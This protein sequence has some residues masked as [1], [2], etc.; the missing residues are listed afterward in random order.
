MKFRHAEVDPNWPYAKRLKEQ[1]GG[2]GRTKFGDGA[3]GK[4]HL[5][6]LDEIKAMPVGKIM[7]AD[8]FI[9]MWVTGPHLHE[10]GD[11]LRTWGF[12]PISCEFVWIKLS[13]KGLRELAKQPMMV[14]ELFNNLENLYEVLLEGIRRLPGNYTAS[15]VEFVVL[16]KRGK[17]KQPRIRMF[18]QLIFSA[19]QEHSRKPDRVKQYIQ[20]AY[21]GSY[22]ELYARRL[23]ENWVTLGN[24]VPGQE[25]L[26]MERSI[27]VIAGLPHG[28]DWQAALLKEKEATEVRK[29]RDEAML[30]PGTQ[31]AYV[32][33]HVREMEEAEE[34][35]HHKDTQLGFVTGHNGSAVFC[36]YWKFGFE[37]TILRTL[38]CSEATD[39]EDLIVHHAV[40]Q[41]YV[42]AWMEE[43]Y[44]HD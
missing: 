20:L 21:G 2:K 11:V 8:S 31:I 40:D 38:S 12:R 30:V 43:L 6:D 7:E 39:Y 24:E 13:L 25:G 4:Y 9:H 3:S 18:P 23:F 42:D 17:P 32:P 19:P 44:G 16:G 10:A 22:V 1:H 26:L 14:L 37:G 15:N 36:R 35:T 28:A 5:S 27:P 29:E 41:Y 33:M 34:W